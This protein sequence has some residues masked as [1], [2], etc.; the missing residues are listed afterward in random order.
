MEKIS[1]LHTNTA[2]K[3][4][5]TDAFW[6]NK[7][8][9][10]LIQNQVGLWNAMQLVIGDVSIMC[11]MTFRHLLKQRDI[12]SPCWGA[13]VI[14]RGPLCVVDVPQLRGQTTADAG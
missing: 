4:H 12:F 14:Y 3:L 1:I 7:F 9:N 11:A 5:S 2:N 8:H 6:L 13:T 10:A